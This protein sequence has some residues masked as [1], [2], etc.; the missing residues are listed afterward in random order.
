MQKLIINAETMFDGN[1]LVSN[2][3]VL[4]SN[5][6]ILKVGKPGDFK[7]AA[8][9]TRFLSPGLIDMHMHL[10]GFAQAYPQIR[11]FEYF[12]K[13]LVYNGVTTVREV[14]SYANTIYN[15]KNSKE[16]RPR[17]YS[18][19]FLDGDKPIWGMSFLIKDKSQVRELIRTCRASGTKW[20]KVYQGIRPELLSTII[21]EAHSSGLKVAGHLGETKSKD[22]CLMGIDTIEHLSYLMGTVG[23][24]SSDFYKA[25]AKTDVDSK[26][27]GELVEALAR[28]RTA[29]CPTLIV[30]QM[31]LFPSPEYSKYMRVLFPY[32][33]AYKNQHPKPHLA[34]ISTAVRTRAFR[35]II[36]LTRRLNESG[37]TLIAGSDATNPFVAPGFSMHQEL[38]LLVASGMTPIEALKT[39]TS[40]AAAVLGNSKLG[41]I[42]LGCSAD[43]VLYSESPVS[44][45]RNSS[46][47]THVV[48]EG[49][50]IKADITELT[51]KS[52][53]KR[54]LP[55][56][57]GPQRHRK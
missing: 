35:N 33:K 46:K 1:V 3:S 44:D 13:M 55:K 50:L 24:A 41:R 30:T 22:A 5:G 37:V 12:N 51:S 2:A 17:I 7:G 15:F 19:I 56:S 49:K 23:R 26:S 18:S 36:K 27:I 38:R 29:V 10:V 11:L 43:L 4:I 53:L 14:G 20:V 28:S 47:I 40:N 31:G 52:T 42:K 9:N 21:K 57:P 54:F 39:A 6:V 48:L 8:V 34:K 25:W 32:T 16:P 45:I